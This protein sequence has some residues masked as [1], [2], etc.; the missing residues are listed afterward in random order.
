MVITARGIRR[1]F[2][3]S[4]VCAAGLV[5]CLLGPFPEIRDVSPALKPLVFDAPSVQMAIIA[6]LATATILSALVLYARA[7]RVDRAVRFRR[8]VGSLVAPRHPIRCA[9][10]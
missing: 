5:F 1:I 3:A 4:L 8:F 10:A 9:L 7:S 6:A 2:L